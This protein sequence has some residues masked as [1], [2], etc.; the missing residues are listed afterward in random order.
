L[1]DAKELHDLLEKVS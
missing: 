1:T